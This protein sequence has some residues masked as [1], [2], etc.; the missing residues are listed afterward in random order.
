M[1]VVKV[2]VVARRE[3]VVVARALGEGGEALVEVLRAVEVV[4]R[5]MVAVARVLA[6]GRGWR[7]G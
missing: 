1:G 2:A 5:G 3:M 4:A 6:G 7:R